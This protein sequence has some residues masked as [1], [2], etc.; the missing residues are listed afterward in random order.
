MRNDKCGENTYPRASWDGRIRPS[1]RLAILLSGNDEWNK[2]L[3]EQRF[4]ECL[5]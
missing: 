2:L 5:D 1:S 3:N 4:I